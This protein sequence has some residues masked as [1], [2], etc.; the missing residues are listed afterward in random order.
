MAL[1]RILA[2]VTYHNNGYLIDSIVSAVTILAIHLSH[3]SFS[4]SSS[5]GNRWGDRDWT[6]DC[7]RIGIVGSDRGDCLS[8]P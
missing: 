3:Q 6:S 1:I 8:E 7:S 4:K 2:D 5:I